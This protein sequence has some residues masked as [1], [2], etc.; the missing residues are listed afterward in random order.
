MWIAL[1]V[2]DDDPFGPDFWDIPYKPVFHKLAED[3]DEPHP[4]DWPMEKWF[5]KAVATMNIMRSD[6][7]RRPVNYERYEQR[8][9]LIR[10]ECNE[11]SI[12]L[13]AAFTALYPLGE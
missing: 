1:V 5:D 2:D 10:N 11:C 12:N 8:I 7:R 13:D 4:H 9:E 6:M 3:N